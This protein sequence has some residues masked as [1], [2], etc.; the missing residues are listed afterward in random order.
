MGICLASSNDSWNCNVICRRGFSSYA[1]CTSHSR[2]RLTSDLA[3]LRYLVQEVLGIFTVPLLRLF[4]AVLRSSLSSLLRVCWV[5]V[6]YPDDLQHHIIFSGF[7]M[8][9]AR[10]KLRDKKE[11]GSVILQSF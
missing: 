8:S 6:T 1:F 2:F 7:H 11:V 9:R 3:N 5:S 10:K 4:L